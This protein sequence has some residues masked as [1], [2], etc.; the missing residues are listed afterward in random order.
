VTSCRRAK[1]WIEEQS[2]G[3]LGVE[4]A[5]QLDA[6]VA[7][8]SACREHRAREQS[9]VDALERLPAPAIER[10]DLDASLRQI[11]AR[12]DAEPKRAPRTS[13]RAWQRVAAALFL[14]GVSAWG[15]SHLAS[16]SAET[17]GRAGTQA[18]APSVARTAPQPIEA[19]AVEQSTPGSLVVGVARPTDLDP[20]RLAHV[21]EQVAEAL[22]RSH[23]AHANGGD[24]AFL[25]GLEAEIGALGLDDWPWR[26]I[27][28]SLVE[29]DADHAAAALRYLGA[30]GDATAVAAIAP[31]LH[32]AATRPAATTAL[33][34]CGP[35]GLDALA[36]A[37]RHE[38]VRV[39]VL[40]HVRTLDGAVATRWLRRGLQQ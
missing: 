19:P 30:R 8:C 34:A 11:H 27:V 6:H 25:D 18:L 5:L 4:D 22:L 16:R 10:L 35:L 32:D 39:Q 28:A 15:W 14:I 23:A 40:E 2:E 24:A 17:D 31:A 13:L 1:K 29:R 26:R 36:V 21:R 33:L 37:V 3:R 38:D 9:L 12:L 7:E 20:E